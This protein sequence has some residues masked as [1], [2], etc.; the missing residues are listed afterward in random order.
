MKKLFVIAFL[1]CSVATAATRHVVIAVGDSLTY[2]YVQN[3]SPYPTRLSTLLSQPVVNL[4]WG[5]DRLA[6]MRSRW[7][8]YGKPFPY[9]AVVIE[10]GTNDIF[11]DS[12]PG[13]TLWATTSAWITEAKGVGQRVIVVLIPPRWGGGGWT[14]EKEIERN[15]YND[16]VRAYVLANP[17]VLLMDSDVVLGDGATPPSL[18]LSYNYGDYT[19]LTSAG[20]QALAVGVAARVSAL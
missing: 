10:G 15:A 18:Q 13:A 2:G 7:Q 12:T 1:G 17:D 9:L 16:A 8:Q 6:S 11:F 19:H 3:P 20:L 4:G 14:N 5:G